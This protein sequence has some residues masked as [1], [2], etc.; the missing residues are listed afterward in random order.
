MKNLFYKKFAGKEIG[1]WIFVLGMPAVFVIAGVLTSNIH[2]SSRASLG[3]SL[4]WPEQ[5]AVIELSVFFPATTRL[6]ASHSI[7]Y[8]YQTAEQKYRSSQVIY[9]LTSGAKSLE[10]VNKYP[11]G[12]EVKIRVNPDFP[13]EAILEYELGDLT[14]L[15]LPLGV[16][17]LLTGLLVARFFY[18]I[19]LTADNFE[20]GR[21][22]HQQAVTD[23]QKKASAPWLSFRKKLVLLKADPSKTFYAFL[24]ASICC[25]ALFYTLGKMLD[26]DQEQ[27]AI[28]SRLEKTTARLLDTRVQ[29]LPQ[30]IGGNRFGPIT[31]G[32]S[33]S[34]D[35]IVLFEPLVLF[36]YEVD[37]Q[38]YQSA[39]L[40]YNLIRYASRELAEARLKTIQSTP[41]LL[42]YYDRDNRAFGVLDPSYENNSNSPFF[43]LIL[44]GAVVSALL[45]VWFS[46]ALS[47]NALI[48]ISR[49]SLPLMLALAFLIV[50]ELASRAWYF[51]TSQRLLPTTGFVTRMGAYGSFPLKIQ[52]S[53][54][55]RH[56]DGVEYFEGGQWRLGHQWVW[57]HDAGYE[58]EQLYPSGQIHPL[59]IDPKNPEIAVLSKEIGTFLSN[60]ALLVFSFFLLILMV[61]RRN[62]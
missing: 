12:K 40:S 44:F 51:P 39:R 34:T 14:R 15:A 58:I 52:V 20:E 61:L 17:L 6:S 4:T 55:Y 32:G 41:D 31:W 28:E 57:S 3:K 60:S 7:I 45:T 59:L 11:E 36:E 37:G 10:L 23:R 24:S 62:Q 49:F 18:R 16:L 33:R 47:G 43:Y 26:R 19:H 1:L 25:L 2:Y 9:G 27:T 30:G 56:P 5:D 29:S 38:L 22:R 53:I 35:N 48:L 46:L 42:V 54:S 50:S 13:A 21:D 8:K